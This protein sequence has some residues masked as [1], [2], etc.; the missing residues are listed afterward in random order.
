MTSAPEYL[1]FVYMKLPSTSTHGYRQ[2]PTPARLHRRSFHYYTETA[3][4]TMFCCPVRSRQ[5]PEDH[6]GT[7]YIYRRLRNCQER[8]APRHPDPSDMSSSTNVARTRPAG[9]KT[10]STTTTL[11]E[12]GTVKFEYRRV[13][14]L[15]PL[16]SPSTTTS[17]DDRERLHRLTRT[18]PRTHASKV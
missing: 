15:L 3:R 6:I 8:Q 7:K 17:H 18:A 10:P 4:S 1:K 13:N 16:P 14:K 9:P 11:E 2:V 12:L 5:V